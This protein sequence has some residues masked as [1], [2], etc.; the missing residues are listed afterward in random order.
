MKYSR[1]VLQRIRD[2]LD[3]VEVVGAYTA[4]KQKG[5]RWW[6]LSPFKTEKT[7]SFTVKPQEG[8]YYCF[9]TQKGGDLFSFVAEMEGLSFPETVAFLAEK[10]GIPLSE[11]AA[12][13]PQEKDRVALYE[14]YKRVTRTFSW[15]LG[16]PAGAAALRY[17]RERG[18]EEES[19]TTFELGYAPDSGVWLHRFLRSKSYS[20][21]FLEKSGLF[22]KK[23]PRYPLFR[24][25]IIFPIADS[26]GRVVAFGGRSMNP[27]DRAKYMNS[28]DTLIYN[29]KEVLYGLPQAR[30]SLRTTRCAYIAEGYTDVIALHQSGVKNVVAPLGTALTEEQVRLLKRWVHEIVL[31]FDADSAGIEASFRAALIVEK[32]ELGCY[33]LSMESGKDPAEIYRDQGP[34]ALRQKALERVPA[35]EY[36]LAMASR[37]FDPRNE[38]SRDLLL[39]K[40]FPYI[41]MVKSEVRRE[42]MLEQASDVVRVSAGAIRSDLRRWI[43]GNEASPYRRGQ[44]QVEER[45]TGPTERRQRRDYTLV[46]ACT[47]RSELFV[48]LRESIAPDDLSDSDARRLFL[49]ADESLRQEE[50]LPQGVLDRLQED[51]LREEILLRLTSGEYEGWSKK[52]ID[53]AVRNIRVRKLEAQQRELES[54]IRAVTANEP[55]KM[56][57]LLEQKMVVDQEL[58]Q[59]KARSDD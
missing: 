20:P 8:F 12:P 19:Y 25:R 17:L 50:P 56:R 40:V 54:A 53:G 44:G 32:F 15:F 18:I 28:P 46:L 2:R 42:A 16:E 57:H 35:F 59:V 43:S 29:K 22:S 6:G 7:P 38:R 14:L 23:H 31:V 37:D 13:D 26:Q 4:L 1:E 9:S 47:Q 49:L 34:D 36:L 39:R 27:D 24:D 30:E 11:E 33:V 41:T 58:L 21:T 48:Y 5:D 3:M 45:G 52:D 51:P 55:Q 10:A